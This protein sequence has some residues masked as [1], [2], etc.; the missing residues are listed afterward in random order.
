M[1]R[2]FCKALMPDHR[3]RLVSRAGE[4]DGARSSAWLRGEL[5]CYLRAVDERGVEDGEAYLKFAA[6]AVLV[7]IAVAFQATLTSVSQRALGPAL[8]VAISGLTTAAVAAGVALFLA[9]PEFT[10]RAVGFA[11]ASGVLGAFIL[12]GIAYS[13]GQ[14][15]VARTLSLVIASQLIVSL[16]LDSVGLFG[17]D[18]QDFSPLTV[19]GVVLILVGGVLVVRY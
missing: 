15:G 11:A 16:V 4:V 17:A 13:A 1:G 14:T 6:L 7:G 19:L 5:L 12:G 2:G 18:G 3:F 9:R 8:L 10:A